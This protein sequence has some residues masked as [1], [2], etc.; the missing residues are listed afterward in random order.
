MTDKIPSSPDAPERKYEDRRQDSWKSFLGQ[1]Y[2]RR[3]RGERRDDIDAAP[4][5]YVDYH[6]P[7]LL[8]MVVLV[9]ILCVADTFNTLTL[10]EHGGE[11]ADVHP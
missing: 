3:R 1:F 11:E 6:E 2:R 9:M 10:I 7:W 8:I 4:T 5:Y